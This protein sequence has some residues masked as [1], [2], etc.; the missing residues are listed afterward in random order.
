MVNA[1]ATY[2]EWQMHWHRAVCLMALVSLWLGGCTTV[3]VAGKKRPLVRHAPLRGHV[4]LSAEGTSNRHGS[5]NSLQ[6]QNASL[7]KEKIR[8]DTTG[9]VYHPTLL[10]YRLGLGLGLVQQSLETTEESRYD[11]GQLQEYELETRW[12]QQKW[13]PLSIYLGRQ[14]DIIPR[15]YMGPIAART[16]TLNVNLPLRIK[17]WPNTLQYGINKTRQQSTASLSNDFLDR[18]DKR[19]KWSLSH[20]FSE[21]SKLDSELQHNQVRQIRLS[22]P[23][24][25][26]EIRYRLSHDLDFGEDQRYDL[27]SFFNYTDQTGTSSFENMQW[28]ERFRIRHTQ[29]LRTDYRFG[30]M[31]MDREVSSNRELRGSAGFEHQ[32]YGSLTTTGRILGSQADLGN[33]NTQ[34]QRGGQLGFNYRKKNPLGIL[35]STYRYSLIETEQLGNRAIGQATNERHVFTDPLPITLN[36]KNVIASSILVMSADRLDIYTEGDDYTISE[37][38][39]FTELQL[40]TLGVIPPNIIDGQTV[41]IDYAFLDDPENRRETR[42]QDFTIRERFKKGVSLYFGHQ[43]QDQEVISTRDTLVPDEFINYT[44][45]AEWGYKKLSL[46]AE[47]REEDSTKIASR[48][49]RLDGRWSWSTGSRSQMSLWASNHWL[50][51]GEPNPRTLVLF[52]TGLIWSL[53]LTERCLASTQINYRDE[54]DSSSGPTRGFQLFSE[55]QHRYRRLETLAGAEYDSLARSTNKRDDVYVYVRIRRSF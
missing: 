23:F 28:D 36:R 37:I 18:T 9:D 1:N 49:K 24:D 55:L 42:R 19:F 39:G 29:R 13:Y 40:T 41:S 11:S 38:N 25:V 47:Y 4:E 32:L 46:L 44:W 30:L 27:R 21:F 3:K 16:D 52:R 5:G 7:A 15:R 53:Q 35:Y 43:R 20:D 26:N 50:D 8:L 31:N 14:E 10:Q 45:G 48:G 12:L 22:S 34:E 54:K 17:N 51:Y 2:S 6:E 33:N